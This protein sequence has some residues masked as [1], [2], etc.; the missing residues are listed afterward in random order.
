MA[1]RSARTPVAPAAGLLGRFA[2]AVHGTLAGVLVVAAALSVQPAQHFTGLVA[3]G[4]SFGG[5]RK[6]GDVVALPL[7]VVAGVLVGLAVTA[8]LSAQTDARRRAGLATH[9]LWWACPGAVALGALALGLSLSA[10]MVGLA[11]VAGLA[12]SLE[13]LLTR[14]AGTVLTP[15]AASTSVLG[16]LLWALVPVAMTA[17]LSRTTLGVAEL[18]ADLPLPALV[19]AFGAGAAIH[20]LW[21]A[22]RGDGAEPV[23]RWFVGLPQCAMPLLVLALQ[24]ARLRLPDGSVDTY[25]SSPGL[26]ILCWIVAAAGVVLCALRL[27]PRAGADERDQGGRPLSPA[28]ALP[29]LLAAMYGATRPPVVSPDDYHYGEALIGWFRYRAGELPYID[30]QP[31]HG[32]AQDDAAALLAS[33]FFDGS[34]AAHTESVRLFSALLA[35]VIFLVVLWASGSLV[36]AGLVTV[37]GA[38]PTVSGL[39]PLSGLT[40]AFLV[41]V[42]WLLVSP[43]L[44][45]RPQWWLVVW[46]VGTPVLVLA[47][48]AQ[49]LVLAIAAGAL[50]V[51]SAVDLLTSGGIARLALPA[52]AVALV[53][54]L[55]VMT[56]LGAMLA[57]ALTYVL[58]NAE[59]NTA[60]YGIPWDPVLVGGGGTPL[61]VDVLRMLWVVGLV[62]CSLVALAE[63]RA[64]RWRGEVLARTVFLALFVGGVLPYVMGRV[65]PGGVSRAGLMTSFVLALV[66]PALVWGRL[67]P[68]GRAALALGLLAAASGLFGWVVQPASVLAAAQPFV[69]SGDLVD[70]S[71]VGLPGWGRAAP[72]DPLNLDQ[73][74]RLG[75]ILDEELAP[76]APYYDA[77]SR[78]AQYYYLG[79]R[80]AVKVTAAYNAPLPA[81]Q[82]RTIR[83]LRRSRPPVAVLLQPLGN[84]VHDGGG[85]A[86][87]TPL[88][89]RYLES[90]YT[91]YEQDGFILGLRGRKPPQSA[92]QPVSLSL[93]DTSDAEWDRGVSRTSSA[94]RLADPAAALVLEDGATL[95]LPDG[96]SRRVT[97]RAAGGVIGLDRR[98][99]DALSAAADRTVTVAAGDVDRQR[100]HAW[101]FERAFG[102]EDLDRLPASWGG[103]LDSIDGISELSEVDGSGRLDLAS[104]S[105]TVPLP[106]VA[107][108]RRAGLVAFDVGCEAEV[109]GAT[110]PVV[111]LSWEAPSTF[112]DAPGR[113]FDA[114]PGRQLVPLDSSAFWRA[115]RRVDALTFTVLDA[116]GCRAVE[117]SDVSLWERR[118]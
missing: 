105:F 90:A 62:L 103:S 116:A 63:L 84:I 6:G 35:A 59:V 12:I 82:R 53:G 61:L 93:D 113:T 66:I 25:D 65:D 1:D 107:D 51:K 73:T 8:A 30:H 22:R 88:L 15:L 101:L 42:G 4:L 11:V 76:G 79:R 64:R 87:R 83:E 9:L 57:A 56:P 115:S 49:G 33:L 54:L 18:V 43:R 72:G 98:L 46:V 55:A 5:G 78:N 44:R 70:G 34:A 74:V 71:E 58:S 38:G 36:L 95:V 112:G 26:M 89:A 37:V 68:S 21:R 60:A 3:G 10:S 114:V 41:A 50:A 118:D 48:P 117:V 109:P 104:P 81:D 20:E 7:G 17:A 97:S 106:A 39:P 29:I 47:A 67:R 75:R 32:L 16:C 92:D 110:P 27:R 108:G 111:R 13:T 19:G 77:T 94:V 99:P 2:A 85:L 86:L 28:A 91:P 45:A 96:S 24:P 31:A 102:R 69:A 40:W 14:R 100:Y 80:P 52:A 23:R